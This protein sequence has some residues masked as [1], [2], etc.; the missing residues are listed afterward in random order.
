MSATQPDDQ[1]PLVPPFLARGA[2]GAV[3]S[4][5][6]LASEA[7]IGILR[8]GGSA[9]DAAI[10]TNAALAVVSSY[11]CGLG[12]DALW[13]IWDGEQLR[14]LNGSGRSGARQTLAA[15]RAAG[16]E[17]MPLRGP[18]TVTVPGA[19]GS[20]AD[21]HEQHGRLPWP[22][23][24]APAIELA[25]GFPVSVGWRTAIESA[26]G[27]FGETSDWATV[28]RPMGRPWTMGE[29]AALPAL[30]ATLGRLAA[31]GSDDFYRGETARRT[32]RYLASAGAPIDAADLAEH[33]S[34]WATPITTSYRG[35]T[36][37]SHP[38][39]STG[40]VALLLLNV[41]ERFPPPGTEAW[42]PEGLSDERWIHLSLE[43]ARLALSERD[44]VLTD[45]DAMAPGALE[46]LLAPAR[47]R[48][49]AEAIDASRVS[50]PLP[51]SA[52]AG[53]GTVYLATADRWGG[54]V[55]LLQSNYAGFG[56]GLVDPA[57][58]IAF[59][60]RGA[61]FS[62]EPGHLNVLAPRKRTMHTLTPGMLLRD[63]R[64]WI[65]HGSMGGEIQP[66][67]FAQ[68]VT[69]VVDGGL[70]I[71]SALATPRF[72][73]DP[74]EHY[75]PPSVTLLESRLSDAIRSGLRDRGHQLELADPFSSGLGHA[76]AIE[77]VHLHPGPMSD[78]QPP[79]LAAAT[80]PR[81]EGLPAA[82]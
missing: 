23:L 18:W 77:I 48:D 34:D 25:G 15:A 22:E 42:G 57:T 21:A 5:H 12:G 19:V 63:G 68:F 82:W 38:P 80:D 65:A 4:P 16:L 72:A 75:T 3:A 44:R 51:F 43:A 9:V 67:V 13:L 69:A 50:R 55:S 20:W 58:G 37:A 49:L 6:H 24:L 10:A 40:A 60:N 71:A 76:H 32:L 36:V 7:G 59:Q 70:D 33:R 52:P 78:G 79:T 54:L 45:P 53:G 64:P 62:L 28:F 8:A 11:M 29:R 26:A 81:S 66:Q 27:A 41:L 47:A 56:S 14:A 74:P 39:N 35:V 1:R 30:A 17:R 46:E 73:A 31:E 61:F 2:Q